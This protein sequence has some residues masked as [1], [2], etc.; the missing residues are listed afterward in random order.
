VISSATGAKFP[1]S[2]KGFFSML[3]ASLMFIFPH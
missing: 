3:V 1:D 2:Q